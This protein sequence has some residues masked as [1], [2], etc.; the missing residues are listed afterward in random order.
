MPSHATIQLIVVWTVR[1]GDVQLCV[2]VTLMLVTYCLINFF[3]FE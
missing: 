1:N 3:A 2:K